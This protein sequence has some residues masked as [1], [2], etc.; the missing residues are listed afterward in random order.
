MRHYV[1]ALYFRQ[2]E[3]SG[4]FGLIGLSYALVSGAVDTKSTRF[5]TNRTIQYK[6]EKYRELS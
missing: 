1:A 2:R 3:A 4:V 6:L 5:I